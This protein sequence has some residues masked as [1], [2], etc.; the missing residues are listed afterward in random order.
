M[1]HTMPPEEKARMALAFFLGFLTS[2][3]LFY[4]CQL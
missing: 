4:L 1:S 2:G 3:T